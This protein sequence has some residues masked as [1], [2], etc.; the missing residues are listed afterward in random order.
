MT[1]TSLSI[2]IWTWED[3][4]MYNIPIEEVDIVKENESNIGKMDWKL[5]NCFL[6]KSRGEVE[7]RV[8]VIINQ[9]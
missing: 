7:V 2:V 4:F 9:K 5:K 6:F 8:E 3:V 1:K